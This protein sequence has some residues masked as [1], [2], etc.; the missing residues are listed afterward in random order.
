MTVKD[1]LSITCTDY[2]EIRI[3][4]YINSGATGNKWIIEKG[5]HYIGIIPEDIL[6]REVIEIVPY[7]AGISV[8]IESVEK[9]EQ[10]Q[11]LNTYCFKY[12]EIY[13]KTYD[14]EAKSYQDA[15][16]K[17]VDGINDGTEKAP[18]ELVKTMLELLN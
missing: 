17:I 5:S 1:F 12:T 9:S 15:Y 7:Y 13:S 16:D 18:D 6:N 3:D 10:E 11:A 8:V 14:V 2:Q 4:E